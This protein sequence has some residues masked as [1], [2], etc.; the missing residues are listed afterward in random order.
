MLQMVQNQE[1]YSKMVRMKH[2][3]QGQDHLKVLYL[4]FLYQL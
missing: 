2:K 4:E 1:G 3:H